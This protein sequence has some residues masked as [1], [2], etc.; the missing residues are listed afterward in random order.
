MVH[1]GLLPGAEVGLPTGVAAVRGDGPILE[2][3]G[4]LPGGGVADAVGVP[5]GSGDAG[6]VVRG[7]VRPGGVAECVS[8]RDGALATG[9]TTAV[10]RDG[11]V[12]GDAGR[13][14][15]SGPRKRTGAGDDLERAPTDEGL[16]ECL[17]TL[18]TRGENARNKIA[19]TT[20]GIARGDTEAQ[21]VAPGYDYRAPSGRKIA[22][23]GRHN[24]SLGR[25]PRIPRRPEQ[26]PGFPD[27]GPGSIIHSDFHL[28]SESASCRRR[29][30][31]PRNSAAS[32]KT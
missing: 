11:A 9:R 23:K 18:R 3:H 4:G 17:A 27:S 19:G 13:F 10:T 2:L 1:R 26:R 31:I 22:L 14:R 30:S 7:G 20:R 6:G 29:L 5:D 21:G 8:G 25:R 32:H 24:R 28:V 15:E 12:G 16:R